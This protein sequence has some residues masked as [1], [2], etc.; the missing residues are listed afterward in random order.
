MSLDD[1][2]TPRTLLRRFVSAASDVPA[3]DVPAP[4]QQDVLASK[5][6]PGQ[7]LVLQNSYILCK[8][9]VLMSKS[10]ILQ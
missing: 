10:F 3:P 6:V 1:S 5:A 4:D 9:C 8:I 2:T 7:Y